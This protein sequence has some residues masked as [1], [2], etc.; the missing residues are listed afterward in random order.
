MPAAPKLG[1]ALGK[2]GAVEVAHQTD[3]EKLG[4]AH[5]HVGIAREIAVN[6]KGKAENAHPKV[7]GGNGVGVGK[8]IVGDGGAIVGDEHLFQQS[9]QDEPHAVD[10]HRTAEFLLDCELGEEL[11]GP[12]DRACDELREKADEGKKARGAA[13]GRQAAAIDVY[14]V[15]RNLKGVETDAHGEQN[16]KYGKVELPAERGA[17]FGEGGGEEV[18]IFENAQDGEIGQYGERTQQLAA[19]VAG[20]VAVFLAHGERQQIVDQARGNHQ[21]EKTHVPPAV[22]HEAGGHEQRVAPFVRHAPIKKKD[23]GQKQEVGRG[24][25]QHAG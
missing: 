23:E 21:S 14:D 18:E 17:G 19:T 20:A 4:R 16:V 11:C 9:P 8:D 12:L 5:S 6:L 24:I 22:E 3:A 25:E 15:A 7:G 10:G 1:N 2:V 13:L